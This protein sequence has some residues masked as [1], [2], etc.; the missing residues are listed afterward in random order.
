M[1]DSRTT[2]GITQCGTADTA[3]SSR[4]VTVGAAIPGPQRKLRGPSMSRRSGQVGRVER[5]GNAFY[6][7][8]WLDVPGEGRR[9][10]ASVRICPT[11]GPGTL[12]PSQRKL[13]CLEIVTESGANSETLCREARG[14]HLGTTFREQSERWLREIQMR[15]RRPVKP[16]TI[17]SW[18]SALR[19]I[20]Q[21]LGSMPL[22]DVKNAAVKQMVSAMVSETSAGAPRFGAK[23]IHNYVQVVKAVVASVIDQD[24]EQLHPV[25]WNHNFMDLPEIRDQKTPAFTAEEVAGIIARSEGQERLLFA[26]LA[27]SG[28]RAG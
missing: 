18:Q 1:T 13:R 22:A 28:L 14:A 8:F 6:A 4:H 10:Y 11:S 27:G 21:H 5:K 3:E 19:W 12:N 23:S 7:R 25:K 26:L 20:N 24:G 16:H 15:K 17:C 2:E 9:K